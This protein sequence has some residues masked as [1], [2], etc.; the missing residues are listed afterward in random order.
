YMTVAHKNYPNIPGIAG[1]SADISRLAEQQRPSELKRTDPE[2]TPAPNAQSTHRSSSLMPDKTRDVLRRIVEGM[3]RANSGAAAP[4]TT[5][6]LPGS[7]TQLGAG[8]RAK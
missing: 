3:R 6:V 7:G 5:G 2:I 4:A 1:V 8:V